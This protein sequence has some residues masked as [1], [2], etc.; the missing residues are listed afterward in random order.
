MVRA[1]Y[2]TPAASGLR[3]ISLNDLRRLVIEATVQVHH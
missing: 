2:M 3:Q 1:A